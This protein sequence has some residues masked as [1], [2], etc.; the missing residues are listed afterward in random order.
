MKALALL[1]LAVV[2]EVA[3]AG[4]GLYSKLTALLVPGAREASKLEER[5]VNLEFFRALGGVDW[6]EITVFKNLSPWQ[7]CKSYFWR[8]RVKWVHFFLGSF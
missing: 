1:L 7:S 4:G 3:A 6:P 2:G 5:V 8:G